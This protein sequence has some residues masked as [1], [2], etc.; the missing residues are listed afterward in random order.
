VYALETPREA[1]IRYC[2]SQVIL[3]SIPYARWA[4]VNGGSRAHS[5]RPSRHA[6]TSAS[7]PSYP[8]TIHQGQRRSWLKLR[9]QTLL[10]SVTTTSP[11]TSIDQHAIGLTMSISSP[12]PQTPRRHGRHQGDRSRHLPPQR[13]LDLAERKALQRCLSLHVRPSISCPSLP[14]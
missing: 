11:S 7:S 4:C 13:L 5:T 8:R 1:M 9:M 12:P 6:L 10:C 3:P 14:P 2:W